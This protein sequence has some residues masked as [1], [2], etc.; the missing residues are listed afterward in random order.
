MKKDRYNQESCFEISK[1]NWVK[2]CYSGQ[3][4]YLSCVL[5][6]S[7]NLIC[8]VYRCH[9]H[10]HHCYYLFIV[11]ILLCIVLYH[12]IEVLHVT[13]YICILDDYFQFKH[14]IKMN[15]LCTYNIKCNHDQYR[16][17]IWNL[18]FLNV[19]KT[20]RTGSLA[21]DRITSKKILNLYPLFPLSPLVFR[22]PILLSLHSIVCSFSI[23]SFFLFYFFLFCIILFFLFP[24]S[25]FPYQPS[26]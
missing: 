21:V 6:C 8:H 2:H 23:F 5:H 1:W 12:V 19:H 24:F 3:K 13:S 18:I 17:K 11:N 14:S 4:W 15:C 22:L 16:F 9:Y 26:L 20:V 25:L 7:I 10:H